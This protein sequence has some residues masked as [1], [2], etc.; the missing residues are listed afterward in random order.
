MPYFLK[1]AKATI[2]TMIT[3]TVTIDII[4]MIDSTMARVGLPVVEIGPK[5]MEMIIRLSR[6]IYI[7]YLPSVDDTPIAHEFKL[8]VIVFDSRQLVVGL[9]SII[10]VCM[11]ENRK[12]RNYAA[13]V[14]L[15]HLIVIVLAV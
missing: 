8:L 5:I 7:D 15:S 10:T 14:L 1:T 13:M 9:R 2:A 6:A 4:T 11:G 3:S 12:F